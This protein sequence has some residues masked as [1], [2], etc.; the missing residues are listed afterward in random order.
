MKKK[1]I[2]Y[3]VIALVFCGVGCSRGKDSVKPTEDT[4][5]AETETTADETVGKD[6]EVASTEEKTTADKTTAEKTTKKDNTTKTET[7][8]KLET[9]TKSETTAKPEATTKKDTSTKATEN[10]TKQQTT[11]K[12]KQNNNDTLKAPDN[13]PSG[14]VMIETDISVSAN[15]TAEQIVSQIITDS[16]SEYDRVKAI[17]DWI[18]VNVQ[19]DY[20]GLQGGTLSRT[21]YS[22][23]GALSYKLAVCQGYA[24]AFHLLCAKAGVQSYI[25]YG[26]AGNARDGWD[27]HAWNVVRINGEWYQVDCTWDD[28]LVNE[29]IVTGRDNLTYTYFLLTDQEM[30]LDHKLDSEYTKNE[31]VCTSTLFYGYAKYLTLD[32]QLSDRSSEVR[33][34]T[35]TQV[36]EAAKK[37]VKQGTYKFRIGIPETITNATDLIQQG[38]CDGFIENGLSGNLQISYAYQQVF[39]YAI[40]EVTVSIN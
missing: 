15:N 5:P 37:F 17:H 34:T 16:M 40:Y 20:A 18:V 13:K 22:A 2:A 36:H 29:M 26:E 35:A 7:T 27:T 10:T 28:P 8:T 31:K 33:V 38:I 1:I 25:M 9:T 32:E 19:Y 4:K 39:D 12:V 24:E 3:L 21:A 23:D 6:A 11:T 30:Y 14:A